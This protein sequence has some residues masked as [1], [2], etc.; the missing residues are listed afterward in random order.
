MGMFN[1]K[2]NDGFYDLG[3][4]VVP[5][6]GE[7]VAEEGVGRVGE[8]TLDGMEAEDEQDGG[9]KGGVSGMVGWKEEKQA[10]K[11]VWVEQ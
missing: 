8:V 1:P 9:G 5:C 3:L 7:R 2:T 6:I 4:A 10:G 11:V